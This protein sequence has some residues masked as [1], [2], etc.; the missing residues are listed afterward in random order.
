VEW[1]HVAQNKEKWRNVVNTVMDYL[2]DRQHCLIRVAFIAATA[3]AA[4]ATGSLG[5]GS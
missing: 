1:I 2:S 3:A 5:L 4:V